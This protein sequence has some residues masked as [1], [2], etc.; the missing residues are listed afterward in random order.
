MSKR[1]L[2]CVVALF[3]AAGITLAANKDGSWTGWVTDTMCGAKGTSEKH[4]ACAKK[5]VDGMGAKYALYNP[6]DKKVYTLDPQDQAAAH[7]GHHV[8]VEGTVDGDTI[9]IKSIKMAPEEA[10]KETPKK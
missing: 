1:L 3:V 10:P 2:I 8:T 6:T 7:A 9:K 4:A 5:C